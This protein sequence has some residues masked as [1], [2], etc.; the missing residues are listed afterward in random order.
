M[1]LSEQ[2][3]AS[4]SQH[5]LKNYDAAVKQLRVFRAAQPITSKSS[6]SS[7]P[8]RLKEDSPIY[9]VRSQS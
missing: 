7:E 3:R 5:T 2:L 4:R 1:S 8:M 6:A 9:Q